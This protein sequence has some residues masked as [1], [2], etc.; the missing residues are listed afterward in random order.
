MYGNNKTTAN[1]GYTVPDPQSFSKSPS[2][3][4]SD[5]SSPPQGVLSPSSVTPVQHMYGSGGP[6]M[7]MPAYYP[8]SHP[9]GMMQ[10]TSTAS[11]PQGHVVM[12]APMSQMPPPQPQQ[13]LNAASPLQQAMQQVVVVQQ[14]T[15]VHGGSES[16]GVNHCCHFL[17][18]LLFPP[19]ILC[20]CSACL[21]GCPKC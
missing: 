2:H 9:Y 6:I 7:P 16:R 21:C 1:Y 18:T 3:G 8:P 15:H 5:P 19:W 17:C 10:Y 11:P 14:S 12:M 13:Q 4:T 20:W